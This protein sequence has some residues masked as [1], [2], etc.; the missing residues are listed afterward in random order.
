M[1]MSPGSIFLASSITVS[2]VNAAGTITHTARGLLELGD[3]LVDGRPPPSRP[4]PASS[5]IASAL[6][7]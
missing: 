3:E 2:P 7:S 5:V 4:R 6:T 1:M